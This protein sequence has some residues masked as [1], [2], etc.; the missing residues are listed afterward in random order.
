M[1]KQARQ[2][3]KPTTAAQQQ[4]QQPPAPPE[5]PE[6]PETPEADA[7]ELDAQ[8]DTA[9]CAAKAVY[10]FGEHIEENALT[11][12]PMELGEYL[13]KFPNAGAQAAYIHMNPGSARK[14]PF[15]EIFHGERVACEVFVFT[16]RL[17]EKEDRIM[18][19][20]LAEVDEEASASK[21]AVEDTTLELT[22]DPLALTDE[23]ERLKKK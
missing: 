17:M 18:K 9:L 4:K 23:A 14:R 19:Q 7:I 8:T 22:E 15:S 20:R 13:R 11:A 6:T 12:K 16:F 5:T 21:V 1:A 2:T 10:G 3:K